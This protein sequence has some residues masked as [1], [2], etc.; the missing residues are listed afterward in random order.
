M[1]ISEV[2][3]QLS[4]LE[5]QVE[6]LETKVDALHSKTDQLTAKLVSI[7]SIIQATSAT[8]KDQELVGAQRVS[9]LEDH[10]RSHKA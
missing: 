8:F 4:D 6:G 1:D 2:D 7:D 10:E 5:N 3:D 9:R